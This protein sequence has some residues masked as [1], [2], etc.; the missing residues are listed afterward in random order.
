M[1]RMLVLSLAG[2]IALALPAA[3]SAQ[4]DSM[5][6]T[7]A[8]GA[9]ISTGDI[10]SMPPLPKGTSTII[11][12]A[13][14]KV[15]PVL[16]Q[17]Q[18]NV[19]GARPMKILFDQ[20][21]QLF[22]NGVK[23]PLR[24]LKPADHA[25][26]QTTLDGAKIF[27]I[28]IHI[29][30]EFPAGQYR[31]RVLRFDRSSGELSL[32]AAPSPQPFRVHVPESTTVTRTGQSAFKSQSAGLGDLTPGSLVEVDFRAEGGKEGV[33]HQIVVLAVPGAAFIFSGNI[34]A[35]DMGG[36]F[37][38]VMDPRDQRS[39]RIAFEPRLVPDG[40]E[41]KVGQQVR[42]AASYDGGSYKASSITPY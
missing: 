1:D 4:S 35:L 39:Y 21:T 41:L 9:N 17:F 40:Q 22:R 31:G 26:V 37:L 34:T 15:D 5:S 28:S 10:G 18:L 12:G 2:S 11:G 27:A 7:K 3:S 29:L 13:I 32:D 8:V 6:G 33:A 25:S 30:S 42:I 38:T 19:Y 20:R 24:D 14:G 36:G 23:V 16:D